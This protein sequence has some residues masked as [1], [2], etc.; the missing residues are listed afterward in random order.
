MGTTVL[1]RH[2]FSVTRIC[3]LPSSLASSTTLDPAADM[4]MSELCPRPQHSQARREGDGQ[5]ELRKTSSAEQNTLCAMSK[6]QM[7]TGSKRG[8][9]CVYL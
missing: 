3:W 4:L 2:E 1:G 5:N 7:I 6:V 8:R 9:N